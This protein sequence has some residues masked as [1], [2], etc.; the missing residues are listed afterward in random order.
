[1]IV[2]RI[3]NVLAGGI[4]L[5]AGL[6]VI[7][8]GI[9]SLLYVLLELVLGTLYP[10]NVLVGTIFVLHNNNTIDLYEA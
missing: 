5:I 2:L 7:A 8:I 1:M 10:S 9:G 4:Y 3:I 6:A